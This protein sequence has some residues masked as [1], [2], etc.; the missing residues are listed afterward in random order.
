MEE[1]IVPPIVLALLFFGVSLAYSSVGLGG[2]SSYTALMAIFGVSHVMIPT[3]SL[4]LN[5]LV[6][7]IGCV[8]FIRE[9][10]ARWR[11]ILPF[12]ITSVPLSYVG[13]LLKMPKEVFYWVLMISLVVVAIRIYCWDSA[14]WKLNLGGVRRIALSL[15]I[16]AILGLVAGIVGI[17]GGIYL[18]PS[19]IILRLGSPKEAAAAGAIFNWVNSLSGLVPRFQFQTINVAEFV[20]LVVA[21]ILGGGLGS[22]LGS[23][24][25]PPRTME[26]I[27]GGI[28]LVAIAFLARKLMSA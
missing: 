13:G 4:T 7:S 14:A 16:G 24:K 18:I 28:V 19:I 5:L 26:K 6:A 25:L 1:L 8:Y 9:R 17:G 22:Y 2:G 10:H 21:V 3:M 27:L 15:V 12:A 23:S 20:P 11:L